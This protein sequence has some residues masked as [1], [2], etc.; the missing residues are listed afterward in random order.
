MTINAAHATAIHPLA[1]QSPLSKNPLG[2]CEQLAKKT[3]NYVK[4]FSLGAVS[5]GILTPTTDIIGSIPVY[6]GW[7]PEVPYTSFIRNYI[8]YE[9]NHL[10]LFKLNPDIILNATCGVKTYV[11]QFNSHPYP[12]IKNLPLT[13]LRF[14]IDLINKIVLLTGIAEEILFRGLVQDVLLTRIPKLIINKMAPGKEKV[15]DTTIA[16][17][18]R[19]LLTSAGFSA[20]HLQNQAVYPGE[21]MKAQ[22][23]TSFI[24]GIGF[25]ILKESKVGL[26]G[27]IGAHMAGNIFFLSPILWSC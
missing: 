8:T 5:A 16:K 2:V 18:A 21:E 14:K 27:T 26:A 3:V 4:H 12:E 19:I 6:L 9:K 24:S 7:I 22:L 23:I 25:G 10:G 13:P 17:A 1:A 15:L 20:V 11:K